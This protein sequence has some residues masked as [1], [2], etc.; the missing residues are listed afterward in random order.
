[1]VLK[2]G[3]REARAKFAEVLGR[4]GYGGE[5]VIV[6]RSGKPMAVILPVDIYEALLGQQSD[7]LAPTGRVSEP[8][9]TVY[10]TPPQRAGRR[11]HRD[12]RSGP[13]ALAWLKAKREEILSI[14]TRY[15]ARN[16]RVFG[17][18]ARGQAT[19]ASDVDILVDLEPG[20]SLLDLGGLLD[21]LQS[22]LGC[23]VDVVTPNT[24]R[25]S[26]RQRVLQ[27]AVPL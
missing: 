20:R 9:A 12:G 3:A 18:A 4:V 8:A 22:L 21:E 19:S 10:Q 13:A 14:A 23:S 26:M 11:A 7:R 17:S 15:G 24:L 27:E 6:E 2:Y 25:D 1:M 16:V 5:V